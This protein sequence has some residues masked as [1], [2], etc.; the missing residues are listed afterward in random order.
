MA[1]ESTVMNATGASV[2]DAY[3]APDI[4]GRNAGTW[5]SRHALVRCLAI[6][7]QIPGAFVACL[8]LFI[9]VNIGAAAQQ[10]LVGR[11]V[12]D[13]ESGR[14]V[15]RLANGAL[16]LSC[17]LRWLG[18]L[19]AVAAGRGLLQYGTGILALVIGQELLSRLRVAILVQVQR[20]DLA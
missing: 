10:H 13:L 4:P 2:S 16:D 12:H 15:V 17:G 18:I 3:Q 9:V 7:R 19:A 5:L 20:L 11:A 14:A 1:G 6:Y 8:F